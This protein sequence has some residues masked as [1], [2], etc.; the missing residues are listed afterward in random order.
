MRESAAWSAREAVAVGRGS[1]A[2]ALCGPARGAAAWPSWWTL[3]AACESGFQVDREE[4]DCKRA[5]E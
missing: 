4:D 2:L 1:G 5:A 3:E